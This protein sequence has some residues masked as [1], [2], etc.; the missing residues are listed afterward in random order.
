MLENLHPTPLV[1]HT[2]QIR[3]NV[4][5]LS[6]PELAG[7]ARSGECDQP[8]CL[9]ALSGEIRG[10]TRANRGPARLSGK[11]I[12]QSRTFWITSEA[13]GRLGR[14]TDHAVTKKNKKNAL[15]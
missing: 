8:V 11:I 3:G 2:E 1:R 7:A 14:G 5:F 12:T 9:S 10:V 15:E 4:F 13:M 6:S